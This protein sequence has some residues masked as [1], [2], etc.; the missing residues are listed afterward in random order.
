MAWNPCTGAWVPATGTGTAYD[1]FHNNNWVSPGT[2]T[3]S[4]TDG[5]YLVH[6]RDR[7]DRAA[8]TTERLPEG[9]SPSHPRNESG[10]TKVGGESF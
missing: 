4:M 8:P 6:G 9:S 3:G 1:H 5:Y 7:T 2:H 10:S